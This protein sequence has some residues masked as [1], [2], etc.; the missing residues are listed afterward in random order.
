VQIQTLWGEL[1]CRLG[2]VSLTLAFV[3]KLAD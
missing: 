3:R 2:S 1:A